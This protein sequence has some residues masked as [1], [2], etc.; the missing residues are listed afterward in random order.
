MMKTSDLTMN[1]V[2]IAAARA[3]STVLSPLLMP[4]YGV[5][6]ILWTSVLCY[7]PTGTR[8]AVLAVILGI[9][10]ILP[11]VFITVLHNLGFIKDKRLIQQTERL[12]PYCFGI[13][14]YVGAAFYM[15]H[16]HSPQWVVM[17]MVGGTVACIITMLVNLKWKISAHLTGIGGIV[18][19]IYQIHIQGLG[20]LNTFWLLCVTILL[21]GIL[22][23]S[24]LVLHR[25][26]LWQVLAGFASGFLCVFFA[27][28]LFG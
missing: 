3:F 12:V 7:L 20:A 5:L 9:T 21:S 17:F 19:L 13:L 24:R 22:G 15:I 26:T 16:I 18:A 27:I 6:L 28:A 10:C 8:M 14:C 2:L 25:H 4:T 23:T 1:R 11:M